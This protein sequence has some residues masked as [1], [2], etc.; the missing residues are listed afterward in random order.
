ML[1]VSYQM[2]GMGDALSGLEVP[3]FGPFQSRLNRSD[4]A[5]AARDI[6]LADLLSA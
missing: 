5:A 3:R 4:L 6:S 1:A 2:G